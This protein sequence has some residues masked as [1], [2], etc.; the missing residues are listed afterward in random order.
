MSPYTV[1]IELHWIKASL[2]LSPMKRDPTTDE[3]RKRMDKENGIERV[4]EEGVRDER[5]ILIIY[6]LFAQLNF[7]LDL[8]IVVFK[9]LL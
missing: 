3:K 7:I 5:V 4:C 2:A 6:L 1:E 8:R 9:H